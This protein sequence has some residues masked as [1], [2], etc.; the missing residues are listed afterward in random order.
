[1]G[2][3]A[4]SCSCSAPLGLGGGDADAAFVDAQV[5]QVG[6][7]I[8]VGRAAAA[9][10]YKT[11]LAQL[12]N[13]RAVLVAGAALASLGVEVQAA[14]AFMGFDFQGVVGVVGHLAQQVVDSTS[15]TIMSVW[16]A[17]IALPLFI[18]LSDLFSD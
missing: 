9:I 8:A 5:V 2:C 18:L 16:R 15:S 12:G 6:Q 17:R 7:A 4:H 10:G 11:Q 14:A 3:C 1:M 13:V